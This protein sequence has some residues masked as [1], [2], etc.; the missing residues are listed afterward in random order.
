MSDLPLMVICLL[1]YCRTDLALR[2][3]R[4]ISTFLRYAG[5][6]EWYVA[7]DGSPAEHTNAIADLLAGLKYKANM[8]S[9]RLGP[10]PSWTLAAQRALSM[11]DLVFW[12]EDDWELRRELD[13]TPYVRLLLEKP[14][15]GM[16]RLGH[17][18]IDLLCDT[19]GYD[20]RHYLHVRKEKQ[21]TYSGNPSIRHR[22]HF[23]AY[24]FYASDLR[25][26]GEN[27]LY[28]DGSVRSRGGPQVWWPVDLGGWGVFG[29]TGEGKA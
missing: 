28:H 13:V 29:H 14:E 18:P 4:G 21:Y 10:G 8:H 15:V 11:A 6:L 19:V 12:L 16:V 27:E 17:L 25:T 2:T 3:I 26:A 20:G 7:D 9:A 24:G 22:R 1:T 5:P 23:D